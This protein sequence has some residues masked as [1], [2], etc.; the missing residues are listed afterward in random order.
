MTGADHLERRDAR[1]EAQE[2]RRYRSWLVG[3][4]AS[5]AVVL[6]G[7][8]DQEDSNQHCGTVKVVVLAEQVPGV[9]KVRARRAMQALGIEEDARWGEVDHAT[10][11]A[12]WAAIADAA[13]RPLRP[14]SQ[15][16]AVG[17][18]LVDE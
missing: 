11:R 4:V 8:F 17:E 16:S 1:A 6:D 12:L 2:I 10:L 3:E 18:L 7:L 9:G 13:T 15:T 5:G 14:A